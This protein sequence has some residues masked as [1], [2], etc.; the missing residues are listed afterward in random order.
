MEVV[1]GWVSVSEEKQDGCSVSFSFGASES[2]KLSLHRTSAST[3]SSCL[4][5]R[6]E[7][8]KN[9]F[10]ERMGKFLCISITART[11]T[12]E[13]STNTHVLHD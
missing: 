7:K 1:G 6:R 8:Y 12:E 2:H 4:Y 13:A 3:S 11:M 9:I 10:A 5:I